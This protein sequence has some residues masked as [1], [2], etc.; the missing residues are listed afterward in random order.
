MRVYSTLVYYSVV[1]M[2]MAGAGRSARQRD[3][4]GVETQRHHRKVATT[5]DKE[6]GGGQPPN[7]AGGN[8]TRDKGGNR[9]QGNPTRQHTPHRESSTRRG[10][11]CKIG[12]G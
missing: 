5:R 1:A 3:A 6:T 8:T 7:T 12:S 2:L 10:P 9:P 4:R 11:R